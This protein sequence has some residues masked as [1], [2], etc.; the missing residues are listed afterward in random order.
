MQPLQPAA[1]FP[2]F[3]A[4][5]RKVL[6][7]LQRKMAEQFGVDPATIEDWEAGRHR[8]TGKRLDL[9]AR[10]LQNW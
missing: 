3:L 7:L 8:P 5:T 10:I 2:K 4:R 1:E 9:I 6:G